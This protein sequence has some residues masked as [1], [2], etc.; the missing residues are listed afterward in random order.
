[1]N[2]FLEVCTVCFH[3]GQNFPVTRVTYYHS[4]VFNNLIFHQWMTT[5]ES[6]RRIKSQSYRQKSASA[7]SSIHYTDRSCLYLCLNNVFYKILFNPPPSPS[8]KFKNPYWTIPLLV[9][10]QNHMWKMK[11]IFIWGAK[12]LNFSLAAF[13]YECLKRDLFSSIKTTGCITDKLR[14]LSQLF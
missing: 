6:L 3:N 5:A 2:T 10:S 14:F 1:M 7:E 9:L 4:P 11:W 13:S 12:V 8:F